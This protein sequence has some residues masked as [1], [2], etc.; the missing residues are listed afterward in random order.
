MWGY[1]SWGY[2]CFIILGDES[3][4]PHLPI[5]CMYF[6][7]IFHLPFYVKNILTP[8]MPRNHL[9]HTIPYRQTFH[10]K[11]DTPV[12]THFPHKFTPLFSTYWSLNKFENPVSH[13]SLVTKTRRNASPL[14]MPADV[15]PFL[16][17]FRSRTLRRLQAG[18]GEEEET[19]EKKDT[20]GRGRE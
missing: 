17:T 12:N 9:P 11:F 6:L 19:E 2:Q 14:S 4:D 7:S 13:K 15:M 18:D 20:G 10:S 8:K 5:F 3:L 16:E 1:P